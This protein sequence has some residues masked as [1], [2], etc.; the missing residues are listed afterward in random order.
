MMKDKKLQLQ[1]GI[2]D[3]IFEKLQNPEDAEILTGWLE[4]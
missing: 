1:V 2:L 3:Y 4:N